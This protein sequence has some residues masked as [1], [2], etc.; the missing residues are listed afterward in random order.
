MSRFKSKVVLVT[1]GSTGIG[2]ATAIAFAKEG[3]VV[4]IG[5]VDDRAQGTVDEIVSLGG[6]ATFIK[7]DVAD[8]E[9][10]NSLIDEC[11]K[12]FGGLDCAFNNAGVLPPTK[13][14]H[15]VSDNDFERI[16]AVDV[17][18]VFNA[19]RA[20][21]G[22][23][24]E[25][26]GGSIVNTASVAGVVADPGMSPYVA[27]KHAV[28][29]LTKAAAIEYAAQGLRINAIAPGLVATPMTQRWLDD[30]NFR[31]ILLAGSPIGRAAQPEEIAG[32]VLHL[33][34]TDASFTNG[35]ITIIDGGQTAH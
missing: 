3:A 23:M 19:M 12:Q 27:A 7:T 10:V 33:C 31:D 17:M 9:Q 8:S 4:M 14:L 29:G 28:V 1:G 5:D 21:I 15:E 35:Q 30:D 25:H 13:M 11:V 24:L 16:I 20:E 34:S 6:K 26:G 18:G 2:H 32:S 22:Y